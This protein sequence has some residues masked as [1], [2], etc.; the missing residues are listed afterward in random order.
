MSIERS[1]VKLIFILF[2]HLRF[3]EYMYTL[4]SR[5][6]RSCVSNKSIFAETDGNEHL[7]KYHN[8]FF[9]L[10]NRLGHGTKM[11]GKRPRY[12]FPLLCHVRLYHA[13]RRMEWSEEDLILN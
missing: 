11:K 10:K 3:E 5:I 2:T 7:F 9:L 13:R 8:P 12:L 6:L 1:S 4:D